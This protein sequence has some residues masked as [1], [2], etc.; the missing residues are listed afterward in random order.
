VTTENTV[1]RPS[2]RGSAIASTVASGNARS[3][4]ASWAAYGWA[5]V[6]SDGASAL[7]SPGVSSGSSWKR[8]K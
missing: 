8:N 3:T 6:V 4:A 2:S 5:M 1:G 7:S